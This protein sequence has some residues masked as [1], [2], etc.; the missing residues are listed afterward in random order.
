MHV[1]VILTDITNYAESLGEISAA[2]EEILGRKGYL[3]CLCTDLATVYERAGL[4]KGKILDLK[5]ILLK[6]R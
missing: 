4:V 3:G 2:G 6:V 5:V 1:F